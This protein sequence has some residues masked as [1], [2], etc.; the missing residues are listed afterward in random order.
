MVYIAP[1]GSIAVSG[2]SLTVAELNA[3]AFTVAL[4][5]TTLE[6]TNLGELAEGGRVNIETD[7]IARQ[8]VCYLKSQ[9]YEQ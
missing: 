3:T 6:R 1:L 5:P 4:I 8:V 2:V 7:M 9:R